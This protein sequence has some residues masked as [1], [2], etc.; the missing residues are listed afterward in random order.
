MRH[1]VDYIKR[2]FDVLSNVRVKGVNNERKVRKA[3]KKKIPR[4][5]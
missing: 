4:N 1:T 5:S 3:L 2:R